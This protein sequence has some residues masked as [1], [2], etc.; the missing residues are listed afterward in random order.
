MSLVWE[1]Y[2]AGG[3]EKLTMLALA[4]WC[5]DNGGSLFPSI[6][7][8]AKKINSSEN[9]ARR[10]VHR[11][12]KSGYLKVVGNN[13]GGNPGQT[14]H[15]QLNLKMLTIPQLDG[16]IIVEGSTIV[17]PYT[18]GTEGVNHS[19]PEPSLT[20]NKTYIAKTPKYRK[21]QESK[22]TS[23]PDDFSIT[24]ELKTWADKQGIT[25]LGDHLGYFIQ[26]CKSQGYL[27]ASWHH[28]FQVAVTRDWANVGH[29]EKRRF[30]PA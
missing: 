15:Y 30:Q 9:W 17:Y 14:R 1:N 10:L 2:K 5:D 28:A 13:N 21:K 24:P 4:D 18:I 16:S 12:I 22:K 7:G 25:N 6:S 11:F 19:V 8:I 27:R 23:I 26:Q 3:S 20:T 29:G